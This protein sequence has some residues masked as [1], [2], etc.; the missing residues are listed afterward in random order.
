M[1]LSY[2]LYEARIPYS[3]SC[4]AEI[5]LITQNSKSATLGS[6]FV[7]I[8]GF[9]ADGHRFA[10]DAYNR[11]C[12]CFLAQKPLEIANDAIVIQVE[13]TKRALGLLADVFYGHPSRKLSVIGITGTKGKTT[14]ALLLQK[15][16]TDNG[17][18]CG[19]IGTNGVLFGE[20]Q[21]S[22]P[23][24]TPDALTLQKT[25]AEMVNHG[26]RAVSLE[27]SS[28]ALMLDRVAG[29]EFDIAAF[30]NLYQDHIG[31]GEH[32]SFAH[33]LACKQKLFSDFDVRRIFYN[34]DDNHALTVVQNKSARMISLSMEKKADYMGTNLSF[35]KEKDSL[36]VEFSI[37]NKDRAV[38]CQLPFIGKENASN[39]LLATAIANDAFG[40]PLDKCAKSAESARISGRSEI[41]S[42]P[43]GALAVIDYA[44]NGE[45]L[46]RLLD[47]LRLYSPRKLICLFGSVGERT[48]LRRKE[49]S[50]A[51]LRLADFSILTSDNPG[52]EFPELI[53][54]D[55]KKPFEGHEERYIAIFDRREAIE[56]AASIL[57]VGDILVLAGK[58]HENYQL[59]GKEKIPFSER[60]ILLSVGGYDKAKNRL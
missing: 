49:L 45:S 53:L 30:T 29:V 43:S 2:L 50:L 60:D 9:H 33:Y 4:D 19:Y 13:D 5:D 20:K 57:S 26:C 58:G 16:L 1:R 51:A 46:A 14:T 24:T 7:C 8:E 27:V 15:I 39:A 38:T 17:I 21:A 28:Q 36:R 48:K 34:A 55:L 40:I 56:Y 32:E 31:P 37:S 18:S 59:I 35:C 11:G 41:V 52:T 47:A 3:L 10:F 54:T 44:H 12:R 25:L 23:N 22:L 42:L 6:L